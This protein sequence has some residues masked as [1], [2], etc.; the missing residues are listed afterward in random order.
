M[1]ALSED[2]SLEYPAKEFQQSVSTALDLNNL[3][4]LRTKN[5]SSFP[6]SSMY[7]IFTYIW[8][9]YGVNVGKYTIHG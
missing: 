9:I 4:M 5:K 2:L 3:Q 6:R 8:V 7:G 1:M